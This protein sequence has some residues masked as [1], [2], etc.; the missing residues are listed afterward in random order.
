ME[1]NL[2]PIVLYVDD[3][4]NNLM[5]FKASFRM[6]FEVM[7]AGSPDEAL[8]VLKTCEPHVIISDYRMPF[9]TGIELFEKIRVKYPKP[10]RVLLT[11]YS[12]VQ[13]LTDAINKGEVYRYIKK[14]WHE[15]EIR[16]VVRESFEYF[17]TR[18]ELET[19]NKE[20]IEAYKD[21]DRFVYSVSHDL[22]SPLMGILAVS[23]L[24]A[25]SQNL[26]EVADY[27]DLISKNVSRLDE[28]IFNLLE[29]YKV[30]RGELTIDAISLKT[31][32]KNL[33]EVYETDARNKGIRIEMDVVQEEEFRSDSL[34]I[35]VALQNLLSNSLKYQRQDNPDKMVKFTV[36]VLRGQANI[37]VED[38]GIGIEPE[39]I[40]KIFEMFFRASVIGTGSG[41]GLYNAKHALDKLG[42]T[43]KVN[44]V[45]NVGTLFEIILPSK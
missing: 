40:D 16:S 37:K 3:E 27:A 38:N 44:S 2:K 45:P 1:T 29:Y 15:D 20:L 35:M 42:A 22:R 39:F 33:I 25:K 12:D 21:L 8:E 26:S 34:V 18:N 31:I 43:V 24:L 6:E 19:R 30:K 23:N 32:I 36:R 41:I 10:L 9:L 5:S 13:S 17:H 11:A 28:F 7:L 4:K 14:P